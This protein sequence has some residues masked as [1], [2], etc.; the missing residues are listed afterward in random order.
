[1]YPAT[2]GTR[3]V[4]VKRYQLEDG[5]TIEPGTVVNFPH[6]AIQNDPDYYPEPGVFR[7]ERFDVEPRKGTYMPFGDGPR[8]CIGEHR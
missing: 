4:C 3:R 7:P 5:L 1:M 6:K 2:P 8:I